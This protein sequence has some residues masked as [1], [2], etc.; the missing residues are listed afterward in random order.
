L[1]LGLYLGSQLGSHLLFYDFEQGL[2]TQIN[3]DDGVGHVGS[4]IATTPG[5]M[6]SQTTRG[7]ERLMTFVAFVFCLIGSHFLMFLAG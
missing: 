3:G 4:G 6:P 7:S 1:Y 5:T 2:R